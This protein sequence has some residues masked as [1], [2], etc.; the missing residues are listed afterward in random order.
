M[1]IISLEEAQTL[2]KGQIRDWVYNAADSTGTLEVK[3]VI[4][5]QLTPRQQRI[6]AFER[7][8]QGPGMTM[9]LR[10]IQVNR[11]KR[12]R[13][14]DNLKRELG[15]EVRKVSKMDLVTSVWDMTE[16]ETGKCPKSTRKD[17]RHTWPRG[18]PDAERSCENCGTPRLK[19]KPFNCNSSQ[20]CKRLLY[21]LLGCKRRYDKDGNVTADEDAIRA[22]GEKYPKVKEL[23]DAILAIRSAKKQLGFLQARLTPSGRYR[24]T[25]TVGG[26]WTARFS[27]SRNPIGEGS[28]PQNIAERHRHIFEA[29]HGYELFYADLERAESCVIAYVSGDE[30]YIKAHEGDTHTHV[31]QIVWPDLG[32]TGD[33]IADKKMASSTYPDWDQAPGHNYRFQSKRVQH[34]CNLGLTPRGLALLAKIPLREAERAYDAYFYEFAG[35][36]AWQNSI[37]EKVETL[38][39]IISPLGRDIPL[40]G[41]PWDEHTYKQGLAAI[42]QSVVADLVNMAIWHVWYNWD[43]RQI[44]LLAQVHDAMMGQWRLEQRDYAAIIVAEAMRIPVQIGERTMVIPVE[45]MAGNN[46]GKRSED[47]PHGMVELE[48]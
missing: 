28:N 16:K 7:A 25:M 26:A 6:Y 34:G 37:R 47:N 8:C 27:G 41:R 44:Q 5:P 1:Q 39:P 43:P 48:V 45:V 32:W 35:V 33:P 15:V 38:Q 11:A 24:Y 36:K 42:P 30:A 18:V 23:T 22:T 21:D 13:A 17:G 29:D 14:I 46:W 3:N 4:R 12:S 19:I 31:C 20:Q 40:F 2:P 10:G 9:M